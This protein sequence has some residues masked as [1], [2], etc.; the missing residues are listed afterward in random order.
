MTPGSRPMKLLIKCRGRGGGK[1]K[2]KEG[3]G[4]TVGERKR[5]RE[6]NITEKHEPVIE[7]DTE[8]ESFPIK[9]S[10]CTIL[11]GFQIVLCRF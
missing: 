2:G 3:K 4:G 9:Q 6:R 8:S 10:G 1:S 11:S 7:Q 5:E